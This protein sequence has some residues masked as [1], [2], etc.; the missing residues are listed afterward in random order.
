MVVERQVFDFLGF[1][2]APIIANFI[3]IAFLIVGIF[4]VH[5][6]RAPYVI[7]VGLLRVI[8]NVLKTSLMGSITVVPKGEILNVNMVLTLIS[9]F[10]T[11]WHVSLTT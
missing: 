4:G 8:I 10:Q 11:L 1:M 7:T 9:N 2:W 3:Q 6:Y 5:Q